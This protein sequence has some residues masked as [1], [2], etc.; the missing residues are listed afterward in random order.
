MALSEPLINMRFA[1]AEGLAADAFSAQTGDSFL[2]VAKELY[3][4]HRT[5]RLVLRLLSTQVE[6]A[7]HTRISRFLAEA[8]PDTK[9]DDALQLLVQMREYLQQPAT[10]MSV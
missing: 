8:A 9:R 10:P 3:F 4:P 7:E 2:R 6:P 1:I 5:V